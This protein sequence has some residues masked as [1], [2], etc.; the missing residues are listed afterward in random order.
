MMQDIR[1]EV[2]QFLTSEVGQATLKGPLALG[3][4]SGALLLSQAVHAPSAEALSCESDADC[5]SGGR[6]EPICSEYDGSTCHQYI[7][8]CDYSDD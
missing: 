2:Q 1:N 8:V 6:C 3:I 5:G 7:F 4:A